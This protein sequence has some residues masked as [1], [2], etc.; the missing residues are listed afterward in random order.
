M[1]LRN[2]FVLGRNIFVIVF[3]HFLNFV[4]TFLDQ[5]QVQ[6]P[7]VKVRALYFGPKRW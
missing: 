5:N 4:H 6:L 3:V 1:E 7:F 2:R